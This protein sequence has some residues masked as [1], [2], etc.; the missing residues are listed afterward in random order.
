MPVMTMKTIREF[1]PE[2]GFLRVHKS[3]IVSVSKIKSFNS[4]RVVTERRK[5]P[6]GR[7][8]RKDFMEKMKALSN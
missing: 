6:V 3:F 2:A 7:H 8:Y 4:E 1:L 5:I